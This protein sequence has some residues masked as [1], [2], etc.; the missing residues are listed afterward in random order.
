MSGGPTIVVKFGE[1]VAAADQAGFVVE[2]DDVLNLDAAGEVK[3]Q[4]YPGDLIHFLMHYDHAKMTVT[5][6]KATSG[7]VVVLG[8]VSRANT[9]EELFVAADEPETLPHTPSGTVTPV[10]YGRTSTLERDGAALTAASVPCLGDI[11]YNYLATSCR[12][13]PPPLTLA[14]DQEYPI[15]VVI[16]VEV[17]TA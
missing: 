17:A 13:V 4:F 8:E 2:L 5:A 15:A 11:S 1:G 16:Y 7:E 12:L 6:I 3:S 14:A 10:W 9:V